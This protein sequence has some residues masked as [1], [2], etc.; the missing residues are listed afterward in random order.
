MSLPV[1]NY[2]NLKPSVPVTL[3]KIPL[4]DCP[5]TTNQMD[6]PFKSML[7]LSSDSPSL[8][9]HTVLSLPRDS[10]LRPRT[11][12]PTFFEGYCCVQLEEADTHSSV[13]LCSTGLFLSHIEMTS[14]ITCSTEVKRTIDLCDDLWGGG[15]RLCVRNE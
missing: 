7:I 10:P 8:V 5:A 3:T 11:P 6:A 1:W 15:F 2:P 14:V 4:S 12:H 9:N 13:Q